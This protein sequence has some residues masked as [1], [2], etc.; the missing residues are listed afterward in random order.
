MAIQEGNYSQAISNF[1]GETTFNAALAK[2]LNGDANGAKT[3]MDNA[4][5][6]SAAAHY[7]MAICYARIGNGQEAKRH[8]DMAVEKDAGLSGKASV[9]LEFRDLD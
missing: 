3:T 6:D 4:G 8:R 5:D 2:L 9:D 1:S 7:V